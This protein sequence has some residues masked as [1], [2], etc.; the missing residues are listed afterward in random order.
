MFYQHQK[1]SYPQH[2]YY[3]LQQKSKE[4][5]ARDYEAWKT[6]NFIP[7]PRKLQLMKE[8]GFIFPENVETVPPGSEMMVSKNPALK[9]R[10]FDNPF[11]FEPKIEPKNEPKVEPK[12]EPEGIHL[13]L[14]QNPL[15]QYQITLP[16]GVTTHG[17]TLVTSTESS[18]LMQ[19]LSQQQHQQYLQ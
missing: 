12:I 15:P 11:S 16:H 4:K 13:N 17:M 2:G 3:R 9:N 8:D 5:N 14:P 18:Q 10:S 19:T 6:G 1:L 7:T